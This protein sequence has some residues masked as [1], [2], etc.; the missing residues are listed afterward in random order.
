MNGLIVIV[1]YA[2]E[3][4]EGK[5]MDVSLC[6][7]KDVPWVLLLGSVAMKMLQHAEIPVLLAPTT[8]RG[9]PLPD[10]RWQTDRWPLDQLHP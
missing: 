2:K 10:R 6:N 5:Q 7:N 1:A 3:C 8:A 9:A 4:G